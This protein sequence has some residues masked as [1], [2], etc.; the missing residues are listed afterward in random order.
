[1]ATYQ[2]LDFTFCQQSYELRQ[3]G[4]LIKL[5]P[6]TAQALEYFI[7]HPQSLITK[8]DLHTALWGNQQGQD[9]KLFQIISE[10]RKLA[11]SDNLIR[12]QPNQGYYWQTSVTIQQ[13]Q[14][15]KTKQPYL[16]AASM[17]ICAALSTGLLMQNTTPIPTP[18][19]VP[20][21][22]SSYS[23]AVNAF[24]QHNYDAAEQWLHFSLQE[25]PHSQE[26]KLL[27]A[28]VKL[29]LAEV[30]LSQQQVAYAKQ[31]AHELLIDADAQS[32]YKGQALSLLSRIAQAHNNVHDALEFAIQGKGLIEQTNAICSAHMFEQQ[33][34][35]LTKIETNQPFQMSESSSTD[36]TLTTQK[37]ALQKT[38]HTNSF[39]SN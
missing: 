34:A 17:A 27:L 35:S 16:I 11:P 33:I 1:M 30:K 10:L 22:L 29:L 37:E 8:A 13:V 28:E 24:Q 18:S 36:T 6:K 38:L 3:S 23:N 39:V 25:N 32:Y 4:E 2:F 9:Y 20:P 21:A 19:S 5:R 7:T 15:K 12:T 14:N 31:L 26:A